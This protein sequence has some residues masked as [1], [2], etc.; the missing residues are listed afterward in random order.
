M[1]QIISLEMVLKELHNISGFRISVHDIHHK[2]IASYPKELTRFCS[3]MQQDAKVYK[4]CVKNDSAAFDQVKKNGQPYIY[5]CQFGLYEAV[6][7]LYY[8]GILSGYLMMGQALDTS[9][10]TK[11]EVYR[12][13]YQYVTSDKALREAIESIPAATKD[14]IASCISIM[15]ICAEYIT[16]SNRFKVSTKNLAQDVKT[17]IQENYDK[18]ITLDRLCKQFYCS[19]ATLTHSFKKTYGETISHFLLRI[20]LEKAEQLLAVSDM[21]IGEVAQRC[22]FL[23]QNYFCK[24][25]I[26]AFGITP[27]AY[28]KNNRALQVSRIDK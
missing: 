24:V 26:K 16:L 7:P 11:E 4:S 28:K 8:S 23:D 21:K 9:L 1:T 5:K 2:E 12:L 14:K 13:S 6:A 22:G 20:R 25:F 27:N 15:G 17:Y 10:Y 3:M 18:K 19:K